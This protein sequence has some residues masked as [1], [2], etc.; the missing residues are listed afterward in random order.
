MD[1]AGRPFRERSPIHFLDRV[2]APMLILQGL[3]DKVVPPAQAEAM[4][5]AFAADAI[6]TWP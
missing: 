2:R 4:V 3:D 5:T 1:R 6:P